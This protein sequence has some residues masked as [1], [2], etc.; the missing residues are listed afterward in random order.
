M[1]QMYTAFAYQ[2]PAM[3]PKMK[4][5]L[6]T[7]LREDGFESVEDAVGADHRRRRR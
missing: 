1:V 4:E 3:L 7:C 2:G 6:A 5:E